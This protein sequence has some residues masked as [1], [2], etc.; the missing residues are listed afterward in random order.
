MKSSVSGVA[1]RKTPF[2]KRKRGR[3]KE[4]WRRYVEKQMKDIDWGWE[5]V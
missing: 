1:M 2:E 3:P 4:T 5:Q